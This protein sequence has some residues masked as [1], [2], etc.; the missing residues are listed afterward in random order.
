MRERAHG[1]QRA[2]VPGEGLRYL[3]K[4]LGHGWSWLG[5]KDGLFAI[6]IFVK[7]LLRRPVRTL[8][9]RLRHLQWF[10]ERKSPDRE[11]EPT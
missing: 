6:V 1:A 9:A 3:M 5:S 7:S 8:G 4:A 11:E 2:T 10:K